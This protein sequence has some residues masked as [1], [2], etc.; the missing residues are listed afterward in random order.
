MRKLT[1]TT[2][3]G[4]PV[5]TTR[6][7]GR[8]MTM[9]KRKRIDQ[10]KKKALITV[11]VGCAAAFGAGLSTLNTSV[12]VDAATVKNAWET[13][14]GFTVDTGIYQSKHVQGVAVDGKGH[15]YFS[16]TDSLIKTDMNGNVVGSVTGIDGTL[17]L[18]DISY[19][20]GKI[21]GSLMTQTS[22]K[23]V[24]NE[25]PYIAIF[26][27]AQI[28]TTGVDAM[29]GSVMQTVSMENV[30]S[31]FIGKGNGVD[32][33]PAS[34]YTGGKYGIYQ[35]LDAVTVGPKFGETEGKDYLT[36][37][38]PAPDVTDNMQRE[39]NR[40]IVLMQFDLD[41]LA[42]YA[43]S[44]DMVTHTVGPDSYDFLN[45]Y[46]AGVYGQVQVVTYD[47]YTQSY[48][49]GTYSE[50]T[51]N[52]IDNKY[53]FYMLDASVAAVE[54]TLKGVD[55][56]GVEGDDTGMLV[57]DKGYGTY[58]SVADMYGMTVGCSTG[59]AATGDGYYYLCTSVKTND[60]YNGKVTLNRWDEGRTNTGYPFVKVSNTFAMTAGASVRQVSPS[61]I[62][63][64]ASMPTAEI[65]EGATFGML[66]MPTSLLGENKLAVGMSNVLD[67]KAT[68][69]YVD[70]DNTCF[71][72]VLIGENG[73]DF[74]EA[75][76]NVPLSA[77]AYIKYTVGEKEVIRY[78]DATVERSVAQVAAA[79]LATGAEN[80]FLTE[81]VDYV[82]SA[83]GGLSVAE[84]ELGL[85]V[86]DT[87]NL[88]VNGTQGL[89][90]I[91]TV[92][93][94]C[95][96]VDE[97]NQIT[98]TAA[99]EGV[100]TVKLGSQTVTVSVTVEE[101]VIISDYEYTVTD[102]KTWGWTLGYGLKT[103]ESDGQA[104]GEPWAHSWYGITEYLTL[105]KISQLVSTVG[106]YAFFGGFALYSDNSE[107]SLTNK[108]CLYAT[109]ASHNT[110]N[111]S[112]AISMSAAEF[113]ELL[114][115]YP[116]A[117]YIR[118]VVKKTGA[119]NLS[120][121]QINGVKWD[122]VADHE[123]TATDVATWGWSYSQLNGQRLDDT[124]GQIASHTDAQQ[125][126]Y[127]YSEYL[128][129]ENVGGFSSTKG[130]KGLKLKV[131][132][133]ADKTGTACIASTEGYQESLSMTADE[134]TTWIAENPTAKYIRFQILRTTSGDFNNTYWFNP[135][136]TAGEDN[137]MNL[138][139]LLFEEEVVTNP[140]YAT[141]TNWNKAFEIS[142][143]DY[144]SRTED[145]KYA[146]AVTASYD[147]D[148]KYGDEA[149]S[150]HIQVTGTINNNDGDEC[151][152][153]HFTEEMFGN[154]IGDSGYTDVKGNGSVPSSNFTVTFR[155]KIV[156]KV[157]G[158]E[159]IAQAGRFER[160][161][162][163]G[164]STNYNSVF[165]NNNNNGGITVSASNADENGWIE[166]TVGFW[167]RFVTTDSNGVLQ[168]AATGALSQ[169]CIA[170]G[171]V[172]DVYV[173]SE[174]TFTGITLPD[175]EEI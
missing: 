85:T 113:A 10:L 45:Y 58:D 56:D 62:R 44:A 72:G 73:V 148:V 43:Q 154:V 99:G 80:E 37:V 153:L 103:T 28:T 47:T 171:G 8:G 94:D 15:V 30:L 17:H 158:R 14:Y 121:G 143:A 102:A 126:R 67:I 75:Y 110:N 119:G 131:F 1:T 77:R 139:G 130:T 140:F 81:I 98:A 31:E 6:Y 4:C 57:D 78:T 64:T 88:I 100:I 109:Q 147:T 83:A 69:T 55:Y 74:G 51:S 33:D 169:M 136:S 145:T 97:N 106:G 27:E 87:A 125:S 82:V 93:G 151:V 36:V 68:K 40:H 160:A 141:A 107:T 32:Y 23:E 129:L 142:A 41:S 5:G 101:E 25:G 70:G 123:Y 52:T 108:N 149:G 174:F 135:T 116:E 124:N 89:S 84:T 76:Y 112:E 127:A 114:A 159:V 173:G 71:N 146:S 170:L 163:V 115:Q 92:T 120:Q 3:L 150:I 105:S 111:S 29:N 18:G 152:Q 172:T 35:G 21:Y 96:T 86:G 34:V 13:D 90:Y 167:N 38:L 117:K 132:L 60:L 2:V 144:D 59:I 166:V 12:N 137:N 134:F 11:C 138:Q 9:I 164:N 50:K 175:S 53:S 79:H 19:H 168:Y 133:Y 91:L 157:A 54:G 161:N 42:T 22:D 26:D 39:D 118:L 63:F 46:Y 24:V 162:N 128:N 165:A 156:T 155:V 16:F 49:I 65:P 95:I 122:L 61:G 104:K 66:L 20:D 48:M 7:N